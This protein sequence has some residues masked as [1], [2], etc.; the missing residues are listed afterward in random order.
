M[1][2]EKEGESE[3]EREDGLGVCWCPKWCSAQVYVNNGQPLT[4]TGWSTNTGW[5]LKN[6][7]KRKVIS[8]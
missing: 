7:T 8:G 5:V 6:K 3:R 1:K 2:E 4:P